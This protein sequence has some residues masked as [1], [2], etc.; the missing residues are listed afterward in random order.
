MKTLDEI[1]NLEDLLILDTSANRLNHTF[2]RDIYNAQRYD[3]LPKSA[4]QAELA[5]MQELHGAFLFENVRV[6]SEVTKELREYERIITEKLRNCN[7][8]EL[9]RTFS[10]FKQK[11]RKERGST[12]KILLHEIQHEIFAICRCSK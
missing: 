10:T 12:S 2:A 7:K 6:V 3:E 5:S 11:Q 1:S 4:L 8:N 9:G